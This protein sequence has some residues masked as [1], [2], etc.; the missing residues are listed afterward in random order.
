M[1]RGN[2]EQD[3][4]TEN[5]DKRGNERAKGKKKEKKKMNE[6]MK[7]IESLGDQEERAGR[8]DKKKKRK[9]EKEERKGNLNQVHSFWSRHIHAFPVPFATQKRHILYQFDMNFHK[10]HNQY[11]WPACESAPQSISEKWDSQGHTGDKDGPGQRNHGSTYHQ[12]HL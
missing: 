9:K 8:K 4:K 3:E 1:E 2:V 11:T 6:G 10:D 5:E 12:Y 7:E